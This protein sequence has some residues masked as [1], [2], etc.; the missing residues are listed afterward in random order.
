MIPK[1]GRPLIIVYGI[2]RNCKRSF[3]ETDTERVKLSQQDKVYKWSIAMCSEG[4]P[5]SGFMA[6]E[7]ARR[8]YDG[9]NRQMYIP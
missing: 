4:K 7:K 9:I 6:T 1:S 2:T 5:V 8:F 3:Q